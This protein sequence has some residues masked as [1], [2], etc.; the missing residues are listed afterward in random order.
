MCV[1]E[2]EKERERERKREKESEGER[3]R[4]GERTILRERESGE[5]I[6]GLANDHENGC[7]QQRKMMVDKELIGFIQMGSAKRYSQ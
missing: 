3:E 1:C 2:R 4:E 5:T 6:I 7:G